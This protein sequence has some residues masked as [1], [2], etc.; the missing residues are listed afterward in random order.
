VVGDVFEV[1]GQIDCRLTK[2]NS[3]DSTIR[4]N[5]SDENLGRHKRPAA[6]KSR[7]GWRRKAGGEASTVISRRRSKAWP[8]EILGPWRGKGREVVAG[9]SVAGEWGPAGEWSLGFR[10]SGRGLPGG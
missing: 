3:F 2:V 5:D 8:P 1:M 10:A 4:V 6:A 7:E 9:R